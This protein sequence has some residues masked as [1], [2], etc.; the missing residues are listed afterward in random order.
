MKRMLL[1]RPLA[2]FPAW[3]LTASLQE[4][5]VK[6]A[7]AAARSAV[8]VSAP[9]IISPWI[10]LFRADMTGFYARLGLSG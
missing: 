3:E 1:F 6:P 2:R 9:L 10:L 7:G 4:S 8:S 5:H